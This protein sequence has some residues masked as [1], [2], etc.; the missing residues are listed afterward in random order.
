[1]STYIKA[2]DTWLDAN[3]IYVK[4]GGAWTRYTM[5]QFS[6]FTFGRV[7]AY[8][9]FVDGAHTLSIAGVNSIT[10]E[11]YSLSALYDGRVIPSTS[12]TWTIVSGG[13]YATI[14]NT[15]TITIL[16]TAAG[17]SVTVRATLGDL[18]ADKSINLTYRSGT[19]AQTETEVVTDASGNT[20]TTTTT[21][22]ENEDGSLSVEET[23]VVTDESGNTV[24]TVES[25]TE[26]N[27]DGSYNGTS[28]S[29][30]ADGNPTETTNESGDT[31]GNVN[32]QEIEY[33]ESG[34]PVV[35]AYTIDTSDN[36][37]GTKNYNGDGTNT[38]YYAFDLTH[39]FV[40]N[41]HFT[42]N[43]RQQPANQNQNHHQIL[44]MKRATP[45]PWY[46]FQL[47]QSSTNAYIQLGTQFSG[48]SNT[49][50]RIDSGT[51]ASANTGE[52]DLTITYNPTAS[53]RCF[54]CH[55]NL[56]NTDA[57]TSNYKF[58]DV[59]ELRYLKVTIGYGVDENNNPYRY[60][61]INV[62]NFSIVRTD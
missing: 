61:N 10:G 1:M 55:N 57:Y 16:N 53:T 58:P 2:G 46:G 17:Q 48:G 25:S 32:T 60:S 44:T 37:D 42:I 49:N 39:G 62:I 41:I 36:P 47:R 54:V 45:E 51:T 18:T 43:F 52:Y 40:L 24:G 27:A 12:C 31:E 8:G 26:T 56:T 11:T 34:D 33:N 4:T 59:P 21:T 29:Y 30:D 38:D 19:T 5:E 50:T 6:A 15:G 35:T 14:D 20:T 22:I 9:G 28:T 3:R 7:F 13:F 23:V